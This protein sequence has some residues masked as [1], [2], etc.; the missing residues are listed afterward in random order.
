MTQTN[1][2][3]Q[4]DTRVILI[5]PKTVCESFNILEYDL[6]HIFSEPGQICPGS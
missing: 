6:F 4:T 2:N 3:R 1:V 5:Y